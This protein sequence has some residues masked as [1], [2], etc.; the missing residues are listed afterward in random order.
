MDENGRLRAC[1][2]ARV[3]KPG[4]GEDTVWVREDTDPAGRVRQTSQ[5]TLFAFQRRMIG[6]QLHRPRPTGEDFIQPPSPARNESVY[7]PLTHRAPTPFDA[8]AFEDG[9]RDHPNRSFAAFIVSGLREGIDTFT[10]VQGTGEVRRNLRSGFEFPDKVTE[11][12][13]AE[14]AA[15]RFYRIPSEGGRPAPHVRPDLHFSPLGTAPKRSYEEGVIKRRVITHHSAGPIHNSKVGSVN[16]DI[17]MQNIVV[18][19]QNILDVLDCVLRFGSDARMSKT[20]IRSA[21][22][23]LPVKPSLQHTQCSEWG[24]VLRAD[25]CLSFGTASGPWSFEQYA[26]AVHYILQK[27]LDRTLGE[28]QVE[29]FHYLD[30]CIMVGR[31]S[32][33]SE[34]GFKTMLRTYK[35]LGVPLSEEKTEAAR[36]QAEFLGLIID[37]GKQCLA[38]PDEKAVD[39]MRELTEILERGKADRKTLR[40]LLGKLG[41]AHAVFPL[42]RP[43]VTEL[44]RLSHKLRSDSH[45]VR[46]SSVALSDVRTWMDILTDRQGLPLGNRD[47]Q[48]DREKAVAE[49]H[50]ACGDAS[51]ETGYGWFTRESFTTVLWESHEKAS[52]TER[53]F[54]NSSTW[55]ETVSLAAATLSWMERKEGGSTFVYFSDADN[56]RLNHTAGRSKN[57]AVN[58]ILR[59]LAVHLIEEKCRLEVVWQPRT[60]PMQQSA[61]FLS[62]GDVEGFRSAAEDNRRLKRIRL[63]R[64]CL[65]QLREASDQKC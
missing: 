18:E 9:L 58:S 57:T 36:S 21:Y 4:E 17:N 3:A 46:L 26:C 43:F 30:D 49:G 22:R 13:Q 45:H 65:R 8:D 20:D 14:E 39:I 42:A 62:R 59:M 34:Q 10:T 64:S 19:F 44:Y 25:L 5:A 32:G 2:I 23:N 31:N 40:R 33:V 24:G 54:A 35:R 1:T 41:F 63:P 56:L 61:D 53:D 29:V 15:G 11:F 47:R 16:G 51:G 52:F 48:A 12:L 27:D 28:D 38:Y 6:K 50:W 7:P 60:H 37:A 55:Q